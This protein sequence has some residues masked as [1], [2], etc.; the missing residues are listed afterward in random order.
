MSW[1]IFFSFL[2]LVHH[3]SSLS[4]SPRFLLLF[5]VSFFCF[6]S[7]FNFNTFQFPIDDLK[8]FRLLFSS[9]YLV[10]YISLWP[11]LRWLVF[12]LRLFFRIRL[13][14]FYVFILQILKYRSQETTR[15]SLDNRSENAQCPIYC[16]H[17]YKLLIIVHL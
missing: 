11:A 1:V 9:S 15:V 4:L 6:L 13:E 17:Y 5:S 3:S 10:I 2:F 12:V 16:T 14:K 8:S 7:P